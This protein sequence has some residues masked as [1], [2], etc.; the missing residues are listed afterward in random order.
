M[1]LA[2]DYK[3]QPSIWTTDRKLKRFKQGEDHAKK[4]Q[5]KRDINY[6]NQVFIYSKALSSKK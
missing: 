6:K 5:E 4:L 1:K 3:D 2:F